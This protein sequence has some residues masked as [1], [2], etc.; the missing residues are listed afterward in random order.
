MASNLTSVNSRFLNKPENIKWENIFL[1][2]RMHFE[3]PK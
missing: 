3:G 1:G 2:F